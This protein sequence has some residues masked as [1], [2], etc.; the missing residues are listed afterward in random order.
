MKISTVA[1]AQVVATSATSAGLAG[2]GPWA[3]AAAVCGAAASL[4]FE[5]ERAPKQAAMIAF[6]ILAMAFLAAVAAVWMPLLP[7]VGA[8]F[9]QIPADARAGAF[10][11]FAGVIYQ[12]LRTI[13]DKRVGSAED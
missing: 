8:Y 13:I 7:T 12:H 10:G 4:Y 5:R 11:L 1:A 6:G 3:W 2:L 9:E